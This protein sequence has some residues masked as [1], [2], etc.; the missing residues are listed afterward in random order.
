VH[1]RPTAAELVA[2][3]RGFLEAELLPALAD[4]RLRFQALVA[5][6][7][8]GVAER[9]L[10]LEGRHL[11]EEWAGLAG[12]LGLDP[13]PPA[14]LRGAVTAAN[15]KLCLEIRQGAFDAPEA[16][17]RLLRELREQVRRKLEVANPKAIV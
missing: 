5:A 11:A 7:V 9:E 3:V 17:A 1:D 13:A 6:N 15:E 12:L 16:A 10:A 8:L 2:A 4:A 14:G